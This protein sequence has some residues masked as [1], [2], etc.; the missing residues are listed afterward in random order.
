[1]K[2]SSHKERDVAKTILPNGLRVITEEMPHV[3]SVAVG[4][5]VDVGSR[6][7]PAEENGIC[8]FIEHMVFKGTA[9]RSAEDIACSV[10]SIGEPLPSPP[11]CSTNTCL[12]AST[13]SRTWF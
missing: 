4:V 7:E 10:D 9:H 2:P 3:R 6:H 11:R 13:C 8:H 5:W 12:A 1:V